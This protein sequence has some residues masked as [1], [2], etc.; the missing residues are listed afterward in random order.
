MELILVGVDRSDTAREAARRAAEL[1]AS[2]DAT[3]H[4]ITCSKSSGDA[5]DRSFLEE[6][7]AELPHD[8]ITSVAAVGDPASVICDEAQRLGAEMIV[9]GS[10]RTQG[11]ARVLGSVAADVLRQSPCNVLVAHTTS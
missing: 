8:R 5:D 1:A 9:V 10:R 3:L 11:A 2:T 4:M 6:L 7:A